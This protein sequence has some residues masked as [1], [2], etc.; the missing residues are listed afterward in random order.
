MMLEPLMLAPT[1][2][3]AP[4][5][6]SVFLLLP[7][8]LW[9]TSS[10]FLCRISSHHGPRSSHHHYTYPFHDALVLTTFVV[11]LAITCMFISELVKKVE[12]HISQYIVHNHKN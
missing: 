6:S 10:W 5:Q 9:F 7:G 8:A 1:L 3:F 11:E 2:R 4:I 12:G